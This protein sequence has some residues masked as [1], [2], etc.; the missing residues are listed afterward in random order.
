M[1]SLVIYKIQL[2]YNEIKRIAI[3]YISSDDYGN[4]LVFILIIHLQTR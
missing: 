3:Q 2:Q 4:N 1:L